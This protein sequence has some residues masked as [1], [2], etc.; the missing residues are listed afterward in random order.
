MFVHIYSHLPP[1]REKINK[2]YHIHHEFHFF[3]IRLIL[4][5]FLF[6]SYYHTIFFFFIFKRVIGFLSLILVWLRF[7]VC[8]FYKK[9]NQRKGGERQLRISGS[10]PGCSLSN[11]RGSPECT[12]E[13]PSTTSQ[14]R[15]RFTGRQQRA[16]TKDSYDD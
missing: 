6:C 5:F 1:P 15:S 9:G 12:G 4:I 8:T 7:A 3:S 2:I 13:S 11:S 10:P 16:K 14:K